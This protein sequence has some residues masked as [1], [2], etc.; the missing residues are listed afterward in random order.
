MAVTA[1]NVCCSSGVLVQGNHH[2]HPAKCQHEQMQYAADTARG[3]MSD[4]NGQQQQQ[5]A[6]SDNER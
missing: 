6:P 5:Q 1:A 4:N 2:T 3:E